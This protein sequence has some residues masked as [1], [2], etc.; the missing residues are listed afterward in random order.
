[1][2]ISCATTKEMMMMMT[3]VQIIVP[4]FPL[5]TNEK[6]ETISTVLFNVYLLK[7]K[8]VIR[9]TT[10][11]APVRLKIW[12]T[13]CLTS[14]GWLKSI[15]RIASMP[16]SLQSFCFLCFEIFINITNHHHSYGEEEQINLQGKTLAVN[17]PH[18]GKQGM[19]AIKNES[20]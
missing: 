5:H 9:N 18:K 19:E 10:T 6:H 20:D 12:S 11:N 13:I 15:K 17:T 16:H 3:T 7:G 4:P 8:W 1:M 2:S 14:R